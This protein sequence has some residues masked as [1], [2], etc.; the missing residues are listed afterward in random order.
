MSVIRYH[1]LWL[2]HKSLSKRT[3]DNAP[4]RDVDFALDF[5]ML[6]LE[7]YIMVTKMGRYF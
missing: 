5:I 3:F 4:S 7:A 6:K 1:E 2:N